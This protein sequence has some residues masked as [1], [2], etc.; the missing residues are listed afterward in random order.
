MVETLQRGDLFFYPC[1][2]SY[3]HAAQDEMSHNNFQQPHTAMRVVIDVVVGIFYIFSLNTINMVI[4][5]AWVSVLLGS[6]ACFVET[7]KIA[8]AHKIDRF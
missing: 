4:S 1:V 6:V 5:T 7:R 8:R 2:S 3:T